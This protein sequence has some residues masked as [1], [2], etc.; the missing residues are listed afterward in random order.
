MKA[1]FYSTKSVEKDLLIKANHN[2]H[3]ITLISNALNTE[4]S[5]HS[6]EKD[7]VIVF[8]SDD[9]TAPVIHKLSALGV[10]YILTRSVG[11]DHID[12]EAAKK[13]GI[14]VANIPVYSPQ[15]IAEHT[16]ALALAL[17]RHLIQADQQCRQFNFCLDHLTGFNFYKKTVGL[18]GLGHVGTATASIFNGLGCKVLG[19][20]IQSPDIKNVEMVDL[21]TL[22][23]T[24]DVI[25]LHIPLNPDTRHLINEA[26]LLKMKNGVMIINTARGDLIKTSAVLDA[27][28][29]G[30]IGYLGLDVYE[31]EKGL[32]FEDHE[33]DEVR[34]ALF[35]EL[36]NYPNVLISPH[37]AFLTKE[38]LEEIATHTINILDSW[39]IMDEN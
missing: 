24:S 25:S 2:K 35:S 19:Y 18:V 3:E 10:K 6:K 5:C 4:T 8:T 22:F 29:S 7:A 21:D 31:Y 15:A 28:K 13:L 38:S 23:R 39:D 26:T 11:T 17:S 20:D 36:M 12:L 16:L 9:V 27:L 34:D 32:F 14:K 1:I 33:A 37:Q 30:K